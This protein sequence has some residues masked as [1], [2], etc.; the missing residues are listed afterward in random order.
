MATAQLEIDV[1]IQQ[2]RDALSE[3]ELYVDGLATDT[4]ERLVQF[5][6]PGGEFSLKFICNETSTASDMRTPVV[7]FKPSDLFFDLLSACRTGNLDDFLIKV[8]CSQSAS[9]K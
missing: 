8:D 7:F 6:F 3:L 9:T 5:L 1:N 2:L 4:R